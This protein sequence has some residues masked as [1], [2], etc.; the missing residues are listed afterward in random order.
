MTTQKRARLFSKNKQ[1]LYI[2]C[3][4]SHRSKISKRADREI[5]KRKVLNHFF[6]RGTVVQIFMNFTGCDKLLN[7]SL[8][9][10]CTEKL[11]RTFLFG[12][13]RHFQPANIQERLLGHPVYQIFA[14]IYMGIAKCVEQSERLRLRLRTSFAAL[15]SCFPLTGRALV[16]RGVQ[17]S[18]PD[19]RLAWDFIT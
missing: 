13:P 8:T 1:L 16:N 15:A 4:K 3:P 5:L 17:S 19:R 7:I 10:G 2:R 11:L 6:L 12:I 14:M 18:S 9:E